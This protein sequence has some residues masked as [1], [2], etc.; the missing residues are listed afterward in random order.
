MQERRT[1]KERG[2]FSNLFSSDYGCT[3]PTHKLLER[4]KSKLRLAA[5]AQNLHNSFSV[6][7]AKY[8]GPPRAKANQSGKQTLTGGQSLTAVIPRLDLHSKQVAAERQVAQ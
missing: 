4:P 3:R 6:P 7:T 2:D 5:A 8:K 1:N